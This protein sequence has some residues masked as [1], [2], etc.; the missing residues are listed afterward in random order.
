MENTNMNKAVN[1]G[2]VIVAMPAV[3]KSTLTRTLTEEGWVV[4]DS[5]SSKFNFKMSADG[6]QY[7]NE[8]GEPVTD[9]K[10]R[11]KNPNFLADY[12]ADI[13]RKMEESNLVFVSAHAEVRE[14]LQSAEIPFIYFT[15]KDNMK[16]AVINRILTRDTPQPNAIIAKVV[17]ANWDL[18]MTQKEI[19]EPVAVV[20]LGAGNYL[21]QYVKEHLYAGEYHFLIST[22][23]IV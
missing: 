23:P 7:V 6:S 19:G 22:D 15:Y 8:D 5:D 18:W 20:E 11:V 1:S 2:L 14:M 17:D 4:A 16:D 13:R 21:A 3:G 12:E 9:A 10:L